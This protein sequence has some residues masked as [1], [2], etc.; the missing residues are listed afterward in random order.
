MRSWSRSSEPL[1]VR[2]IAGML[3]DESFVVLRAQPLVENAAEQKDGPDREE[4]QRP[5]SRAQARQVEE[6]DLA[7]ADGE[8]DEPAAAQQSALLLQAD[9]EGDE[10]E[11]TPEGADDGLAAL[12]VRMHGS[13]RD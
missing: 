2:A 8:E 6:E 7:E 13:P 4:G 1:A 9:V 3:L 11:Q 10:R 12:E 5:L